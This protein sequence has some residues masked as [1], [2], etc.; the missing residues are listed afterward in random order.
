MNRTATLIVAR[1]GDPSATE[2]TEFADPDAARDAL[3][4]RFGDSIHCRDEFSGT[5]GSR[6]TG[7]VFQASYTWRIA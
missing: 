6:G 7:R 3:V 1:I 4:A 2:Y 5:I